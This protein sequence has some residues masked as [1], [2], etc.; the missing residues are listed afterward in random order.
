[1]AADGHRR[2]DMARADRVGSGG[3]DLITAIVRTELA[4]DWDTYRP[5]IQRWESR[6]RPAPPPTEPNR[7]GRPRVNTRFSEWMMGWPEGWVTDPAIGLSR[8]D[9]LWVIGNGVC[10]QQA[11]TALAALGV[12]ERNTRHLCRDLAE[13]SCPAAVDGYCLGGYTGRNGE[14]RNDPMCHG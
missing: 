11:T 12:A 3:E 1:M 6:T 9:Q 7:H 5:A 2:Q 14:Y 4:D 13:G 10:L 8:P